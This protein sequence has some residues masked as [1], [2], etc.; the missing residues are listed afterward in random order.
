MIQRKQTL[1]L[2]FA[3]IL[4]ILNFFN[5]FVHTNDLSFSV[6]QIKQLN[7]A[8]PIIIKT[9]PIAIYLIL[10]SLL[11]LFTILL[12]KNRIIQM[13]FTVLCI[14][15]SVGFYALLF[16]YHFLA[17]KQQISISLNQYH[18]S[19]ISLLLAAIFDYMAF[20][21]IRKDEKIVRD[22]NRLR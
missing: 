22:S 20:G 2:F 18:Y 15:L 12:F 17:S 16:F 9:Y 21:G 14:L 5:P 7:I 10:L 11:H 6:F 4:I 19:L 1:Y 3:A 8:N 13:R